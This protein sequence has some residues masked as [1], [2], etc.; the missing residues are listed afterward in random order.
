M[1]ASKRI[2][3]SE[4]IERKIKFN[5]II[6]K[7][8]NI[9]PYDYNF[10]IIENYIKKF[11]FFDYK[12]LCDFKEYY[13]KKNKFLIKIKK[14]SRYEM[15]EIS[16]LL[17][18]LPIVKCLLKKETKEKYQKNYCESESKK[19]YSQFEK[20]R[21]NKNKKRYEKLSKAQE[22]VQQVEPEFLDKLMGIY[23]RKNTSQEN[24]MY[25]FSEVEKYYCQKTVDF[26]RKVH[27][28]EYNNQ[29]RESSIFKITGMG[30]LYKIKKR[31]VYSYKN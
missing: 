17:K 6:K 19:L 15:P 9:L 26:F 22:L 16:F 5:K 10:E 20:E 21:E 28:T 8:I 12:E 27:D 25:L 18:N 23:F 14:K 7:I 3:E 13:D 24:R 30:S 2:F 11:Y 29:L 31:E 4:L 1:G